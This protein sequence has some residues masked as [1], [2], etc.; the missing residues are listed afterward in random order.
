MP[1]KQPATE[2]VVASADA[3]AAAVAAIRTA[4]HEH[5]LS[6]VVRTGEIVVEHVYGGDA[7]AC[8]LRG[9]R[10]TSL[11]LLAERLRDEGIA[12]SAP[13]LYRA[14]GVYELERR[15]SVSA[16]KHITTTHCY[17][18]LPLPAATQE[19]LLRLADEERWTTRQLEAAAHAA[20]EGRPEGRGRPP[21]PRFEK[22]VNRMAKLLQDPGDAFGDLDDEHL[23][24]LDPERVAALH[25]K[26]GQLMEHLVAL[27]RKLEPRLTRP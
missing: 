13:S 7:E 12:L 9:P 19:R 17:A 4:A 10:D 15:M 27:Q 8:R 2:L 6:M 11:R 5:M 21:L 3:I 18:V 22:S 24:A 20:S 1:R 25:Q 26:A 14:T 16:L 23:D